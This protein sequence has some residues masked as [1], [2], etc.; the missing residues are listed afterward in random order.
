MGGAALHEPLEE[1][2]VLL[3]PRLLQLLVE[4]HVVPAWRRGRRASGEA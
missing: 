3:C 1:V 4:G 2:A